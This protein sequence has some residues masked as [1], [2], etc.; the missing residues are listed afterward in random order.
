[1][2]AV[3]PVRLAPGIEIGDGA[4]P[5]VIAGPCVMES[6]ELLERAL[7]FLKGACATR[8]VPFVFKSSYDKANRTSAGSFRGPGL[9]RGLEWAA[10]LKREHGPFALLL[11]V[12]APGEPERA[13]AVADVLQVPAFLCR[14]TDFVAEVARAGRAVNI[15]KGQFL[16]PDDIPHVAEKARS[17]GATGIT[18]TERGASF[19]YHNLVVD[20]RAIPW[21]RSFGVP[22]IFDATH[23]VQLPGGAKGNSGGLRRFVRPLARAAAAAGADGFFFEVHPDPDRALCDG[24]NMIDFALFETVLD[25]CLAISRAVPRLA[26]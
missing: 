12:H 10:R 19:G 14:Q 6:Y 9:A 7:L 23:A 22:V 5:V 4:P 24:P 15:K 1:M 11:D 17:A 3:P 21:I 18:V 2:T 20:M 13:A 16:A 26:D 8:G 25:E